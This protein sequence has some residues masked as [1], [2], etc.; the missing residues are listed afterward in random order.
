MGAVLIALVVIVLLV[1]LGVAALGLALK[2]LWWALLG[3]VIGALARLVVPG[4]QAMG[5]LMTILVGVGGA[6]LGGIIADA[7][8]VGSVIQFV[9]AVAVA[10]LLVA[11]VGG[12]RRRGVFA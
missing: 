4:R 1:V 12:S 5:I 9:I 8:G 7:L 3:L 2:L 11:L 6:L 10:A